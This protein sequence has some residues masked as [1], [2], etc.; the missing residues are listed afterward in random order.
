MNFY[1]YMVR[2]HINKDGPRGDLARDM[3]EDKEKFP[4][5]GVGKYRGWYKIIKDYLVRQGACDGCIEIFEE[6]WLEYEALERAK[7][8]KRRQK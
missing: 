6:C 5:N 8:D 3:K 4:K 7:C 2:N 1:N